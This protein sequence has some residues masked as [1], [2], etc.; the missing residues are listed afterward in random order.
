MP[1]RAC[2]WA[3]IDDTHMRPDGSGPQADTSAARAMAATKT[4]RPPGDAAGSPQNIG[5]QQTSYQL[6][7]CNYIQIVIKSKNQKMK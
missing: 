6:V 4:E 2:I 3:H 7:G 1:A 5:W